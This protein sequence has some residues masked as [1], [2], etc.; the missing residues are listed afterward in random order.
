[1]RLF[2]LC[3]RLKVFP[4]FMAA[5]AWLWGMGVSASVFQKGK[6]VVISNLHVIDDDLYVWG[7]D[8][9][10]EGTING[11]LTVGAMGVKIYG[12]V[13]R[14][15]NVSGLKVLYAGKCGGAYR[16]CVY[17]QTIE[18]VV[19]GSAVAIG[20]L[21]ELGKGAVVEHDFW[22]AGGTLRLDGL[23]KG[24]VWARVRHIVIT[25]Q[26]NGN[27]ELHSENLTIRPPAIINGNLTYYSNNAPDIDTA[28]VTITG[29]VRHERPDSGALEHRLSIVQNTL[30]RIS[31][32][33]AAFLLGAIL[34][35]FCCP[36][37]ETSFRL[38]TANFATS[39]AAGL[40]LLGVIVLSLI[41]LM[42][43]AL[44]GLIGQALIASGGAG[45]VFGSILLVFSILALPISGF[46][47]LSG[48]IIF[49]LGRIVV[50][51]LVGG[52]VTR[53]LSADRRVPGYG[54]MFL[55]LLILSALFAVPYAGTLI[56]LVVATIGAGALVVGVKRCREAMRQ[57][58][59]G[60]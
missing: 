9:S 19:G 60:A 11:D 30:F 1:M 23:V 37:V 28:G 34:L 4:L 13:S 17:E 29:T 6:Q 27:V 7:E 57:S 46:F 54:A 40:V 32:L 15:V 48:S 58:A 14:A 52:L 42:M 25:G 49:Y 33:I 3:H 22:A 24:R 12:Q 50:A 31:G 26:I 18:G 56:Y 59:A 45:S 8:F 44:A 39:L 16:S 55:G 53:Q 43:S 51:L 35:R 38:V 20:N 41:V 10:M 5:G 21:I 36:Y 2:T 47:G